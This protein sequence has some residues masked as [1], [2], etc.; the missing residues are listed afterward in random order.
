MGVTGRRARRTRGGAGVIDVEIG[1]IVL[2]GL[3][4]SPALITDAL[5]AELVARLGSATIRGDWAPAG[6]EVIVMGHPIVP[7][8][9]E[10]EIGASLGSIAVEAIV[11]TQRRPEHGSESHAPADRT[12]A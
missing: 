8:A 12:H 4:G 1:R 10:R 9:G 6:V 7:L 5:V 11:D 2:S 3:A